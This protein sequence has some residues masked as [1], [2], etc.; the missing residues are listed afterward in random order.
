MGVPK[1]FLQEDTMAQPRINDLVTASIGSAA[2]FRQAINNNFD[3]IRDEWSGV[4]VG[5]EDQQAEAE[6]KVRLG[7]LWIVT[8]ED[9]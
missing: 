3:I 4:Y 8:S 2:A 1:H 5:S 6:E 9:V 7:G